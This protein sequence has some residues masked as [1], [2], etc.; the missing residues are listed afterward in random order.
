MPETAL[1]HLSTAAL[2]TVPRQRGHQATLPWLGWAGLGWVR[3][4]QSPPAWGE[5]QLEDNSDNI[6]YSG[7][8]P[9]LVEEDAF[10][11]QLQNANV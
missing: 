2:Q 11:T 7:E 5:R 4:V 10:I 9:S 3:R 8:Q 1:Q 6:P